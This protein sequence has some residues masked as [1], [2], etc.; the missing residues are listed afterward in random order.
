MMNDSMKE[1]IIE[2]IDNLLSIIDKYNIKNIGTQVNQ[3]QILKEEVN[4]NQE[5]SLRD[6][7]TMYKALF[8]PHGGLSDIYYWDN[9][10]D[11]RKQTNETIA[12]LNGII[13]NY[14]LERENL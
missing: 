14:L 9:D 7:L 10:L 3:L 1:I 4:T 8:P 2:T 12:E 13:A 5:M 11:L 6:K